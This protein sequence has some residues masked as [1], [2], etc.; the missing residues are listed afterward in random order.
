[1]NSMKADSISL[2]EFIGASK[3]TFYIP[4]Y[5]RNYDWKKDNCLTLF[6]DIESIALDSNRD[7]H[8]MGTIVYIEGESNATFRSFTIIDG[9]QRL[10]TIMLLLKAIVDLSDNQDLKADITECYLTNRHCPENLRIKLK[11]MKSDSLNYRKLIDGQINDMESTQI[12]ENYRLFVDLI[13][14]SKLSTEEIYLGIQKLEIV[15]IQL[16]KDKENPQ[17]IFES[18]NSTGLD[19]TQADLIRNFLLMGQEPE[20]QE[21][22][23]NE[24]WI[25]LEEML[26]DAII[27]D[28]I[29]DYLTMKTGSIPNKSSVYLYF[30]KYYN[31]L[32]NYDAEGFLD[33]LIT[34]GEYYSWF[35]YC[36]SS[37]AK[38]N[39]YLK[40]LQQLK[41]TVVYPFLLSLFED[42]FMY[43]NI[44]VQ[45]VCDTLSLLISY[46][47]RRLIC[48]KPTNV[49]N[50][51]FASLAKDIEKYEKQRVCQRVIRVLASKKGKAAFPNDKVLREKLLVRDMYKFPHIKFVLEAV[52]SSLSKEV[53]NPDNLTIEHIMPKSLT[54][55][56]RID[57]GKKAQDTYD[58]YINCIG[59]LT[60]TGYNSELSNKSF[61]DKKKMYLKS[62]VT[63]TKSIARYEHWVEE[64]IIARSEELIKQISTVWIC[65][66][67][68][69]SAKSEVDTRTEFDFTDEIDVTGRTP[70]EINLFGEART[71]V[72]WKSFLETVCKVMYEFDSQIFRS[73]IKHPDFK[74]KSRRIISDNPQD[75]RRH[76]QIANN[77]YIEK[78]LS[79]NDVL[80]YSKLIVEKYDDNLEDCTFRL[81]SVD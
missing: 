37:N 60:L 70:K 27:S 23:Y 78:N 48:E 26:P 71:V 53:V 30:K 7:I 65:P 81:N 17:L 15:Y 10:T 76:I 72:S 11:P 47:L 58:K 21:K 29:R 36:N 68:I 73:L 25:K 13:K 34:Y 14:E 50:K 80:N 74:G 1:M 67:I 41:S 4:V 12:L 46:V 40:H 18:L 42:C 52:E 62:N 22:L 8:F 38:I 44:E 3:R 39:E 35:K 63:I 28:F 75:L 79:A 56:W 32:D 31:S 33:E 2:L 6:K 5:Q 45:D 49:L 9:Q 55:R 57:L 54:S 59:N 16:N 20:V 77:L 66:D 24:Y 64:D 61:E 19:L 51:V 43:H 69:N